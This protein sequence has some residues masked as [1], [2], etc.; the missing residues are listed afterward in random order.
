MQPFQIMQVKIA[1]DAQPESK[2]VPRDVA[3][4]VTN[5]VI[6]KQSIDSSHYSLDRTKVRLSTTEIYIVAKS[7]DLASA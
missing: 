6:E 5:E 1:H 3:P 4:Y 7:R 2:L